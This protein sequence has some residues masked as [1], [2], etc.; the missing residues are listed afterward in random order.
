VCDL[1]PGNP[2]APIHISRGIAVLSNR[3]TTKH[4]LCVSCEGLFSKSEDYLARL[5]EPD[6][7]QIKFFRNV[8]RLDT[9]R[10]TLALLNNAEDSA[11]LAY[12]AASIVWRGCVMTGGCRLGPYEA[13]FRQYL[14]GESPFP[15]AASIFVALLE[16]SSDLDARGWITEPVS[17]KSGRS[18]IH[19][20]LI[21]GL[22]FRC[23][24]GRSIPPE[25]RKASLAE[26]HSEKYV[27]ILR[28]EQCPDFLAAAEMV[29][30]AEPRGKLAK[31]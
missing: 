4:L 28:P 12:F 13:K 8:T 18:W 25:W 16:K 17:S 26:I 11:H 5:T 2:T 24:V 7:G 23:L 21:A 29:G 27:S 6:D 10:K 9:P 1:D 14:L 3:Q 19:G 15:S 31:P 22:A 20:F 30:T